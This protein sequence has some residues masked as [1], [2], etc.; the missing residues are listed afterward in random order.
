MSKNKKRKKSQ[1]N[2][3]ITRGI[4]TVLE[5]EPKQNFNYKQI[6]NKLQI[7][8]TEGRNLLINRLGELKAKNRILEESRGKYKAISNGN[9][10]EGRV[11]ITARGNAYVIIDDADEDVFVPYNKLKR[12]FHG[13][14]VEVSVYP[15]RKTKKLEGQIVNIL[16][17]KK[18]TFVGV[19]D[20]QKTFAFVRPTDFKMYTD[21]FI[22]LEKIG[23]AKHG[24]KVVVGITEWPEKLIHQLVK[25]LKF[26][27]CRGNTTRRYT[28]F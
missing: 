19:V 20:L 28:P 21:I 3:E 8:D 9:Y 16:E 24:E 10:S 14:I 11:E 1:R 15:R 23:G 22:P 27:E 13:D 12:A 17:R 7:T 5:K 4:F 25:Y 26:W 6:A 2:N 18:N